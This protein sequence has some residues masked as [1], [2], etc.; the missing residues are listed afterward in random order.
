MLQIQTQRKLC[1]QTLDLSEAGRTTYILLEDILPN[2]E[3]YYSITV[4]LVGPK[5]CECRTV[6]DIT[7]N[8]QFAMRLFWMICRGT[9]TPCTLTEVLSDLLP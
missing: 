2:G 3:R 8:R 4:E 6:R 5:G 7:G 1:T 9:V